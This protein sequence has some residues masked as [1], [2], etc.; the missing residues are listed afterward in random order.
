MLS[1]L[2]NL[3][4]LDPSVN[5]RSSVSSSVRDRTTGI[6]AEEKHAKPR[7]SSFLTPQQMQS[8]L[9]QQ[10]QQLGASTNSAGDR[11]SFSK[12][13]ASGSDAF[14]NVRLLRSS[15]CLKPDKK[16]AAVFHNKLGSSIPFAH[17]FYS[18]PGS[19]YLAC[20]N[21]ASG[22]KVSSRLAMLQV[23]S[24]RIH[25]TSPSIFLFLFLN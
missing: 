3:R 15:Y 2:W 23:T 22:G 25:S 7:E 18:P 14:K 17:E 10:Q 21:V 13:T 5:P 16:Q 19:C 1:R 6:T 20:T 12:A 9:L 11:T 8:K 4:E 24:F